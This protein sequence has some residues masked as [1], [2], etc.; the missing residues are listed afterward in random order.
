M[1]CG[2]KPYNPKNQKQKCC[3]GQLHTLTHLSTNT[4]H[5][6]CCGTHLIVNTSLETCCTSAQMQVLYQTKPSF[7]CCGHL[8]YNTSQHSCCAGNLRPLSKQSGARGPLRN[9]HSGDCQ[10]LHFANLMISE[11]CNTTVFMGTVDSVAVNGTSRSVLLKNVLQIQGAKSVTA[12]P[13]ARLLPLDHCSCP[14]MSQ[15]I[16]Y[17]WIPGNNGK[18]Q[19]SDLS[20][21][22]SPL[23][24]VLSK[25]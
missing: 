24:A 12:E 19:I 10:L 18:G 20:Q 16:L 17:L 3:S 13:T 9:G 25:C 21:L 1:C 14:P 7:S 11:L 6:E 23:Y 4:S 15:G 22:D 8:Y 5:S 2:V